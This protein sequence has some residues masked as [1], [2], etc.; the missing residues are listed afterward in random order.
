MPLFSAKPALNK[1][2]SN[3]L[4]DESDITGDDLEKVTGGYF[5]GSQKRTV[6]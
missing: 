2:D 5:D 4:F 6:R 3:M 1:H